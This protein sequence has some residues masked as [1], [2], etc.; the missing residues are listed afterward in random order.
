VALQRLR[1]VAIAA[2]K[3]G[4]GHEAAIGQASVEPSM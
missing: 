1:S 2:S 4:N 3:P